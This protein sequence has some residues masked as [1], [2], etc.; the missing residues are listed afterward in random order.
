MVKNKPGT[1][2]LEE[3]KLQKPLVE[4]DEGPIDFGAPP[5]HVQPDFDSDKDFAFRAQFI[6]IRLDLKVREQFCSTFPNFFCAKRNVR[7]CGFCRRSFLCQP[8]RMRLTDL[9]CRATS[10]F[11][12]RFSRFVRSCLELQQASTIRE[13]KSC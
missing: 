12:H 1:S 13:A 5:E 9:I 10:V 3:L 11:T 8:T 4:D 7:S 6:P 2:G